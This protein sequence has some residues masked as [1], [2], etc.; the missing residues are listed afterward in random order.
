VIYRTGYYNP[1]PSAMIKGSM[2][3]V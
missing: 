1:G 3:I 2:V